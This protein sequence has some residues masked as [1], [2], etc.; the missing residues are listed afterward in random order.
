MALSYN[1]VLSV[2]DILYLSN[3]PEVLDAKD[4]LNKLNVVYFSVSIPDLMKEKIKEKMGLDLSNVD[5]VPMRWI[6]GDTKP[7]VDFCSHS[8]DNT[9]LMYMNDNQGKLIVE[10]ESYPITQ[11]SAY[12]F[13][14][15]MHH[16]TVET[17][18]EP[19]LLLGPMNERGLTV[20][21]VFIV[22]FSSEYGA[23]N[24]DGTYFLAQNNLNYNVGTYDFGSIGSYTR[25]KIASNSTGP[26]SQS[27]IYDNGDILSSGGVYYVY[28]YTESSNTKL[29][30][31]KNQQ[32]ALRQSYKF[33]P[34]WKA[35]R[36]YEKRAI[37]FGFTRIDFVDYKILYKKNH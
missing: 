15:G 18:Y 37:K 34:V 25:W 13:N 27:A 2:E 21:T 35:Y 17:G 11:G 14:E 5:K 6:Q 22:Y 8:F 28:P 4:R 26:S 33:S 16:E 32:Q 23:L 29:K 10:R 36:Y 20:G 9:Y 24:L 3:L 12:V 1:Q 19:R 30:R 7:H 31:P